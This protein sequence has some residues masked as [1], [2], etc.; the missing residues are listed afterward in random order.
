MSMLCFEHFLSFIFLSTFTL[1]L[2]GSYGFFV[3]QCSHHYMGLSFRNFIY[4][5]WITR[6][7]GLFMLCDKNTLFCLYGFLIGTKCQSSD[8]VIAATHILLK[9]NR[10]MF[11]IDLPFKKCSI[12][13]KCS[14]TLIVISITIIIIIILFKKQVSKLPV[15]KAAVDLQFTK[16]MYCTE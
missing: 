13:I 4:S 10:E 9:C 15:F 6:H 11:L 2:V 3:T 1:Q 5:F 14:L 8:I 12:N 16:M 7:N